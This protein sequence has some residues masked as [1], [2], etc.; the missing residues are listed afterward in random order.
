M[1]FN[2]LSDVSIINESTGYISRSLSGKYLYRKNRIISRAKVSNSGYIVT[3]PNIYL[4]SALSTITAPMP[5]Q[6]LSN[7]YIPRRILKVG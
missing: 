5:S 1:L 4:I 3:F 2:I 6:R 7:A